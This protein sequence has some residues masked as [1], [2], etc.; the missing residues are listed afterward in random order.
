MAVG[1]D[2]EHPGEVL[3]KRLAEGGGAGHGGE[4]GL[5]EVLHGLRGDAGGREGEGLVEDHDF[6][7]EVGWV[8]FFELEERRRLCQE[9]LGFSDFF[10]F[11]GYTSDIVESD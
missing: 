4:E 7:G 8:A 5:D 3:E 6:F 1:Y 9:W 10:R 2:G 11:L